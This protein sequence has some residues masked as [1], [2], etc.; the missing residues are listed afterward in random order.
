MEDQRTCGMGLAEHAVLPA[1][2]GELMASVAENLELHK[3]ALDFNDSTSKKEYD[4]YLELAGDHREI[5][6][7][8]ETTARK[9]AGYW[10]LPMG[11]HDQHVMSA[12]KIVASF[13]KLVRIEEELVALLQKR[14]E[15]DHRLLNEAIGAGGREG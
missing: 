10:D 2:M 11:K 9:M 7:K 3:E 13:Q 14:V 15:Q 12:P 8:L 1:K 5:A 4:A 6:G